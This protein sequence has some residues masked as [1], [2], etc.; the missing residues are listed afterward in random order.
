MQG[1]A[2]SP[3][4]ESSDFDDPALTCGWK[5]PLKCAIKRKSVREITPTYWRKLIEVGVPIETARMIAW[6]IARYD[7]GKKQPDTLQ[8]K[9]ISQYCRFI[10]RAGLWR[11]NLLGESLMESVG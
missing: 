1:P 7:V 2:E 9:L 10:C 4:A 11:V 6:A 5:F 3:A 8:K